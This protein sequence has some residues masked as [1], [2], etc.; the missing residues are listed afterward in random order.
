MSSA[1]EIGLRAPKGTDEFLDTT[2]QP[3]S[4]VGRGRLH[5]QLIGPAGG[6]QVIASGSRYTGSTRSTPNSTG[7]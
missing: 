4:G 3:E 2:G 1:R 7:R 5:G 6:S